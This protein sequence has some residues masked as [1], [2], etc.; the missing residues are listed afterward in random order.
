MAL[1]PHSVEEYTRACRGW[2]DPPHASTDATCGKLSHV[3]FWDVSRNAMRPS[4]S[5]K[6]RYVNKRAVCIH[7]YR[8]MHSI[9]GG[10]SGRCR[11]SASCTC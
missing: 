1:K 2:Q 11:P 7:L 5:D 9:M 4:G 8:R 3:C 10:T 6:A